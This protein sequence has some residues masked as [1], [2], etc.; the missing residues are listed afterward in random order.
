MRGFHGGAEIRITREDLK[1]A[2]E[3][4]INSKILRA[5]LIDGVNHH[6]VDEVTLHPRT[7]YVARISIS[8]RE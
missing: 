8:V 2:L 6:V 4:A 3:Y 5:G 1:K 7:K